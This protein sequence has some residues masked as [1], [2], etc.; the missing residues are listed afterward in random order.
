MCLADCH[1]LE[2]PGVVSVMCCKNNDLCDKCSKSGRKKQILPA[3][4]TIWN[5]II[6]IHKYG[7]YNI[8]RIIHFQENMCKK[9]LFVFIKY[10][11]KNHKGFSLQNIHLSTTSFCYDFSLIHF[12]LIHPRLRWVDIV[13]ICAVINVCSYF[14]QYEVSYNIFKMNAMELYTQNS[15]SR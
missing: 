8:A 9:I 3:S 12:S 15:V 11:L 13:V 2:S 6:N 7:T 1:T 4:G 5:F 10:N 14:S